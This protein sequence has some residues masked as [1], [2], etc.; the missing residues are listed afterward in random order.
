MEAIGGATDHKKTV[1][2]EHIYHWDKF[3]A[4][5]EL[6]ENEIWKPYSHH[7]AFVIKKSSPNKIRVSGRDFMIKTHPASMQSI[8][9]RLI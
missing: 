1:F 5:I 7:K 6:T 4:D 3:F 2:L 8:S 9:K